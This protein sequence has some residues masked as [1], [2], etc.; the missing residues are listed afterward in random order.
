HVPKGVHQSLNLW[1]GSLQS[2][3]TLDGKPVSVGTVV[4]NQLDKVVAKVQSTLFA[5]ARLTIAIDFPRGY[6]LEVK[7]TPDILWA[8]DNEHASEVVHRDEYS[9]T[10]HRVIDD[11]QHYVQISWQ[12][13]ARLVKRGEHSYR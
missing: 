3:F 2:D 10:F 7:N 9:A 13:A 12:G 4:D 1:Q 5:S 6:D 8:P 11:A